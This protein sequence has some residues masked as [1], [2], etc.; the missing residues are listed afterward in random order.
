MMYSIFKRLFDTLS[1][2]LLLIVISPVMAIIAIIVRINL[3]SPIFY[4]QIRSG[5]NQRPFKLYKFRTMSE[6][7]DNNGNPLPDHLRVTKFGL[8]LR[9]SSLDELPELFNIIKGDM[10]VIGPRPLP[11]SYDEYYKEWE[12]VRFNVLGGLVTPGSVDP[13]PIISWD[14]QFQYEA[15]YAQN[16]CLINDLKILFGVFRILVKRNKID[17]G[18]F[19]RKPLHQERSKLQEKL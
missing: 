13:R 6:K 10:A 5:K 2:I 7:K 3:G 15:R 12:L 8:W 19:E 9:S 16:V 14:E 18:A 1:A 4:S 11:S 17:Y